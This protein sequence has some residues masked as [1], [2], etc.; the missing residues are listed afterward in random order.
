MPLTIANNIA[1]LQAQRQF[2]RATQ[3]LTKIN[4]QLPSGFRIN[5]TNDD[6]AGLAIAES[7]KVDRRVFLQGYAT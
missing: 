4:E 2:G 7:L 3:S 5:R 6:A 1:S